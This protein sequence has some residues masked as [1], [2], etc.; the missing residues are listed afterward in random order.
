MSN[1]LGPYR[2]FM[3]H[4]FEE[5]HAQKSGGGLPN[6]TIQNIGETGRDG[7]IVG[8]HGGFEYASFVVNVTLDGGPG[9]QFAFSSDDIPQ[10]K[11]LMR[12]LSGW[13]AFIEACSPGD[14]D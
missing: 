12:C 6:L 3:K 11:Q 9:Y 10:A 8:P 13:I 5:A 4:L 2:A 14:L 7:L 1:D